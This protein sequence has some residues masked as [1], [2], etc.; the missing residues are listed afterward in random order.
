M[1]RADF[2]TAVPKVIKNTGTDQGPKIRMW[3]KFRA[4]R[5][6]EGPVTTGYLRDY[7][8]Y[9]LDKDYQST[10][11]YL[12]IAVSLEEENIEEPLFLRNYSKLRA[13][14]DARLKK[15]V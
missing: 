5:P 9:L 2:T 10:N 13:Q 6:K 3:K 1:P 4:L 8:N 7:A 12:S 11:C 15:K 14:V